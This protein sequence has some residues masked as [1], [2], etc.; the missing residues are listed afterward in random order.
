MTKKSLTNYH[1]NIALPHATEH[2]PCRSKEG[3]FIACKSQNI[4]CLLSLGGPIRLTER[5]CV[6]LMRMVGK[7]AGNVYFNF[8]II[9]FMLYYRSQ[10]INS[11]GI[12][13]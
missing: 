9:N 2:A 13:P 11:C 3:Y 4:V 10:V 1:A 12:L 8:E 5:A 6:I 7:H